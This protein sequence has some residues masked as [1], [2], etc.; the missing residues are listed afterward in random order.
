[1]TIITGPLGD[2][3]ADKLSDSSSNIAFQSIGG[4]GGDDILIGDPVKGTNFVF[5]NNWGNDIVIGGSGVDTLDFSNLDSINGLTS[6]LTQENVLNIAKLGPGRA[7]IRSEERR[8]GK[9]G[10]SR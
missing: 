7:T 4:G 3:V 5:R 6:G 1:M 2:S 10:R 8:V 9:E